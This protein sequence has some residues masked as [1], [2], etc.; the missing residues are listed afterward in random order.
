M[1]C[2]CYDYGV[3]QKSSVRPNLE[4]V[5]NLFQ[6]DSNGCSNWI[7]VDRVKNADL[8]WTN[9]GNVRRGIVFGVKEYNWDFKREN[10]RR[11]VEMRLV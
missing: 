10:N 3:I 2:V 4:K 1:G 9:N 11:I 8:S 6:P 7:T 5:V